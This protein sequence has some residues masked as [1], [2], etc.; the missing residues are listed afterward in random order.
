[1]VYRTTKTMKEESAALSGPGITMAMA[2]KSN[3]ESAARYAAEQRQR[4]IEQLAR[5]IYF[6][7]LESDPVDAGNFTPKF[8]SEFSFEYA[9]GFYAELDK[10][11]AGKCQ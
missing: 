11:R 5:E 6:R 2:E 1:M 9:E 8:Y 7:I 4:D 10:R 3:A